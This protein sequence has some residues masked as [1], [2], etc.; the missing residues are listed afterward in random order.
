MHLP[1]PE[2]DIPTGRPSPADVGEQAAR[3]GATPAQQ[4]E[5][6]ADAITAELRQYHH[7][8]I[9]AATV[10]AHAVQ[11][12][13]ADDQDWPNRAADAFDAIERALF[14]GRMYEWAALSG[15]ATTTVR[16]GRVISQIARDRIPS[17]PGLEVWEV[18]G[19]VRAE[20]ENRARSWLA[21]SH[22]QDALDDWDTFD[23][24][25]ADVAD[26]MVQHLTA[27]PADQ[28][29]ALTPSQVLADARA[30]GA[31][32][33]HVLDAVTVA[34]AAVLA[35]A[36]GADF[37]ELLP[38]VYADVRERAH[39]WVH[40]TLGLQVGDS[41]DYIAELGAD[42]VA[43]MLDHVEQFARQYDTYAG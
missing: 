2:Y 43:G 35:S 11:L 16:L 13:T 3:E 33:E 36:A 19:Q 7:P 5:R 14:D 12:M 30:A 9:P 29:A 42:N 20:T 26:A 4:I 23:S 39:G 6:V 28:I 40:E 31:R 1:T 38:A 17:T 8:L 10:H 34:I 22:H 41:T 27:V 18:I 15:Q 21:A 32:P 24:L 25:P 37:Y